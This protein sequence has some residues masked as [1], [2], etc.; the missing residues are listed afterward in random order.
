MSTDKTLQQFE[1]KMLT[2]VSPLEQ[3]SVE[4]KAKVEAQPV[5]ND[6]DLAK[7]VALKKE[8]TAHNKLVSDTRLTLTRPLDDMKK[9]II[10]R[11][12]EILLPLDQ[13]RAEISEKILTYEEKL[14]AERRA[15]EQRVGRIV[16]SIE[17]VFRY[18]MTRE[19]VAEAKE[20]LATIKGG[21][22]ESD[23]KLSQVQLAFTVVSNKFEDRLAA[24]K[25]EEERAEAQ[26]KLDEQAKKQ[27]EERAQLEREK[28]EVAEKE[29][30]IQAEKER[31]EREKQRKAEEEKA[32]EERKAQETADKA[33]VKT[34]AR[35]RLV[36]NITD[37]TL[38]PREFCSPDEKKIRAYIQ[39]HKD[40]V[41]TDGIAGVEIRQERVL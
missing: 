34:G 27:S 23:A 26:R 17:G 36:F 35:T 9:T 38:V 6:Q 18:G 10:N 29:R 24:I 37:P 41:M 21:I 30:K 14:E 25:E 7:A 33:R 16:E 40:T 39:D 28:A 5:E 4:L 32:E 15:E 8:I 13:A 11:E 20:K 1:D 31:L 2:E 3:K 22:A 12:R 19:Q